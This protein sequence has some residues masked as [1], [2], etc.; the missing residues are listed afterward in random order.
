M[1]LVGKLLLLSALGCGATGVLLL[2]DHGPL[3]LALCA[4]A[5]ADLALVGVLRWR[6][7]A[8]PGLS[9]Q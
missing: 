5:L 7:P 4:L 6:A 1:G 2:Q 3:G 9:A 8:A